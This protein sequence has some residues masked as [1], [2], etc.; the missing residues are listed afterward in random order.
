[1]EAKE[2]VKKRRKTIKPVSNG[3]LLTDRQGNINDLT[4]NPEHY[5]INP[6]RFHFLTDY[7]YDLFGVTYKQGSRRVYV[8]FATGFVCYL[9]GLIIAFCIGFAKTYATTLVPY[10]LPLLTIIVMNVLRWAEEPFANHLNKAREA[11]IIDDDHYIN[12]ID[13][14]LRK[15]NDKRPVLFIYFMSL[16]FWL[17]VIAIRY[18][19]PNSTLGMYTAILIPDTM[20]TSWFTG[21]NLFVKM[22][23]AMWLL[24]IP[25]LNFAYAIYLPVLVISGWNHLVLK[26]PVVPIPSFIISRFSSFIYF[27]FHVVVSFAIAVLVFIVIYGGKFEPP[28]I[29][30]ASLFAL[31]GLFSMFVP[32]Y[33]I[34]HIVY[35]AREQVGNVVLRRYFRDIYPIAAGTA[36]V[37][38]II[39][40]EEVSNLYVEFN[41]LQELMNN[42]TEGSEHLYPL[43]LILPIILSQAIPFLGFLYPLI[44]S[45]FPLN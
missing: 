13:K 32:L 35:R 22:I 1:M 34:S 14:F 5:N 25:L 43:N 27:Y 19:A 6:N 12:E 23:I 8:S 37:K 39:P 2:G 40:K 38:V 7:I 28:L 45:H 9:I 16:V 42:A 20:P 3:E 29:I 30:L 15:I 11:F 44:V 18:L 24:V 31:L 26:W 21:P 33:T 4:F 10:L 41:E 17:I 36:E